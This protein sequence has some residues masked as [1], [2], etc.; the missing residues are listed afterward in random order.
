[1]YPIYIQQ[2]INFSGP[3]ASF[4]LFPMQLDSEFMEP[5]SHIPI[6]TNFQWDSSILPFVQ[7]QN[8]SSYC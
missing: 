2:H 6:C 1:M 3:L 5:N 4:L 8:P 7:K